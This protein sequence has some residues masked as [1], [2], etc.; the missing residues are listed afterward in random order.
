MVPVLRNVP[1]L[2][3]DEEDDDDQPL[4]LTLSCSAQHAASYL[5]MPSAGLPYKPLTE[6]TLS[7]L[8]WRALKQNAR[9]YYYYPYY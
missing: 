9:Y 1:S 4:K 6:K 7:S 3:D 8:R 2:E 5:C